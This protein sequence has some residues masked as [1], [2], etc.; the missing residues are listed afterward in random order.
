[1]NHQGDLLPTMCIISC[2]TRKSVVSSGRPGRSLNHVTSSVEGISA[3]LNA[4][5]G[6]LD[7]GLRAF[8]RSRCTRNYERTPLSGFFTTGKGHSGTARKNLDGLFG[9]PSKAG[10]PPRIDRIEGLFSDLVLRQS[11][12]YCQGMGWLESVRFRVVIVSTCMV[13]ALWASAPCALQYLLDPVP[14]GRV[15]QTQTDDDAVMN[16]T[17]VCSADYATGTRPS[18]SGHALLPMVSVSS[19][20]CVAAYV[21]IPRQSSLLFE[22]VLRRPDVPVPKLRS[23]LIG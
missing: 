1:V 14:Q 4:P 2:Q 3:L 8:S 13:V 15:G 6:S 9:I 22:E 10:S 16:T 7:R 20:P 17:C 19:Q 21:S 11:L 18:I 23:P 5:I 12:D